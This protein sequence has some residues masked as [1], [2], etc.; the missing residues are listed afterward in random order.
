M[1]ESSRVI[2]GWGENGGEAM[3]VGVR[4]NCVRG[5]LRGG[6]VCVFKQEC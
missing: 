4:V 5:A 3:S 6:S 1:N 2:L